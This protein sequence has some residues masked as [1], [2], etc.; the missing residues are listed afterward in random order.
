VAVAFLF[1]AL[2]NSLYFADHSIAKRISG[3]LIKEL[4]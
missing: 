3:D 4:G 2:V 1:T